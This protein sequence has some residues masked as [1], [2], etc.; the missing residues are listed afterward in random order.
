VRG[1]LRDDV[2]TEVVNNLRFYEFY[3]FKWGLVR[4]ACD[5]TM[6]I[7]ALRYTYSIDLGLELWYGFRIV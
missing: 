2:S 6:R 5:E 3:P 7:A 1:V 4:S